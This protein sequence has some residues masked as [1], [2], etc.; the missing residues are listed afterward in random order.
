MADLRNG[1][2]IRC[3]RR[4]SRSQNYGAIAL[5]LALV[6]ISLAISRSAFAGGDREV[7]P[8]YYFGNGHRYEYTMTAERI[9]RAPQWN[10]RIEP[11]PP[12]SAAEAIIKS[13]ACIEKIPTGSTAGL[14]LT[15]ENYWELREL[16]L[17]K[18]L[19]GWAW[20]VSYQL[21]SRGPMTGDW[22]IMD[23]W[24]LMDGTVLEPW[25]VSQGFRWQQ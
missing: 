24:V 5:S 12:V 7:H 17:R 1:S 18:V 14:G 20:D 23:C 3:R 9:D 21:T 2:G 13:K 8:T 15:P 22:P 6:A 19:H 10:E 11:N 16:G 4:A 25:E